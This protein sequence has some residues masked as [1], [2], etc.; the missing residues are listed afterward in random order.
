MKK[1]RS[2]HIIYSTRCVNNY[3]VSDMI[4]NDKPNLKWIYLTFQIL[5]FKY[6]ILVSSANQNVETEQLKSQQQY[7]SKQLISDLK[8]QLGALCRKESFN[9][10][11]GIQV[12]IYI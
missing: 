12:C 2:I 6:L 7:A 9:K 5:N 11:K 8:L 3:P 10:E 4:Q 1:T